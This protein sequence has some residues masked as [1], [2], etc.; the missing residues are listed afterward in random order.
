[1]KSGIFAMQEIK[2]AVCREHGKPMEIETVMLRGPISGEVEVTLEACA[3]CFSDISAY[4]GGWDDP[5]PA[6]FGHEAAGRISAIGEGV[7][8]Y[9]VGDKV[10]VT[11][12]R[13]CG[14]CKPCASGT[15]VHCDVGY[16]RM[17]GPISLPD[18]SPVSHGVNCGAFAEKVVVLASQIVLQ[19]AHPRP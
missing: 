5:L 11:L 3:I 10:I 13:S 17:T 9:E 15:P 19:S 2:A 16:D 8:G 4:E 14:Q 7:S 6:V 12:I 18:G 1:M